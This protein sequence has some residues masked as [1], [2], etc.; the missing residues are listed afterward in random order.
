MKR[1]YKQCR[2]SLGVGGRDLE[3]D[4]LRKEVMGQILAQ[5]QPRMYPLKEKCDFFSPC[6]IKMLL[7]FNH[8]ISF[9]K[10]L[11]I[12]HVDETI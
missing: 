6:Y 4:R 8:L 7:I 5:P 1:L 10:N 3:V 2:L 11:V 9:K 12:Y